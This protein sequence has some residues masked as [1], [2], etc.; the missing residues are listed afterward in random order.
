MADTGSLNVMTDTAKIYNATTYSRNTELA[1]KS[2][3][4]GQ[5]SSI[6]T[7]AAIINEGA[8]GILKQMNV[9]DVNSTADSLSK[10]I[11]AKTTGKGGGTNLS[12]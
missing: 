11:V 6:G 5:S 9:G 3:P 10:L 4:V 8:R 2:G 12:A 7:S 1:R